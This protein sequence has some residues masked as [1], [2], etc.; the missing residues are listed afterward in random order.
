MAAHGSIYRPGDNPPASKFYIQGK[1]GRLC[2][3]LPPFSL[4]TQSMRAQ[5]RKLG[6]RNGPMDAVDDLTAQPSSLIVN[7]AFSVSDAEAGLTHT[8][9]VFAAAQRL[10]R[11]HYQRI[12]LHEFLPKTVVRPSMRGRT[13]SPRRFI[14]WQT[15]F[16]LGDRRV[17]NNKRIDIKPATVLFNLPGMPGSEPQLAA[18]IART[19]PTSWPAARPPARSVGASWPAR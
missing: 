9:E 1:S 11:W 4:D 2:G 14:D 12:V 7:P 16:D 15:F 19:K 6:A 3:N 10:V 5:L 8:A 18:R 17:R 13:R